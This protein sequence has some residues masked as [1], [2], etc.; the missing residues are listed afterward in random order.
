MLW[1]SKKQFVVAHASD[2]G[3]SLFDLTLMYCDNKNAIQIAHDSIFCDR[4]KHLEFDCHLTHHHLQ[5][6]TVSLPFVS[7]TLQL[8]NFFTKSHAISR[9]Q[10][11][12]GKLSMPL[13]APL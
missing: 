12:L 3:V 4:T 2:M 6:G 8:A 5:H 1:K 9:F 7:S 10:F 13:A 11:L